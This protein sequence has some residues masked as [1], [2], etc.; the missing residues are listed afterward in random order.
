MRTHRLLAALGNLNGIMN[1][2]GGRWATVMGAPIWVF[3]TQ[4]TGW[5]PASLVADEP[6]GLIS[7]TGYLVG[8]VATGFTSF[9][10]YWL[11]SCLVRRFRGESASSGI[12]E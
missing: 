8:G 6:S 7:L 10:T 5:T 1:T 11:T 2:A 9:A 3:L 12:S 4:K